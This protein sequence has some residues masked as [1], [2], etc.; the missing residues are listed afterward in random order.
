MV[1]SIIEGAPLWVWPV[2]AFLVWTG[3]RATSERVVT[4]W[5]L[6]VM[7]FI[8]VLSVNAVAGLP[9]ASGLWAIFAVAYLLGG[10]LGFR[11]QS[12]RVYGKHDGQVRLAGEWLTFAVLMAVFWM[13]FAGGVAQ[14]ISPDV[15]ASAAFTLTFTAIAGLAAG[16]FCGRAICT[17]RIEPNSKSMPA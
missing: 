7:P 3:L 1:F 10:V 16:S 6:Y 13:N 8:G 11:Y 9:P 12:P 14:A 17:W 2:L 15:Y 4:A 5:P